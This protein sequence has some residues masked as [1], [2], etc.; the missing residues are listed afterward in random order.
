[1][2]P[3]AELTSSPHK[4]GA[5]CK[6]T[7]W[8]AQMAQRMADWPELLTLIQDLMAL[9]KLKEMMQL[10]WGSAIGNTD[11]VARFK[12]QIQKSVACSAANACNLGNNG[13]A[14]TGSQSPMS[15]PWMECNDAVSLVYIPASRRLE[16]DLELR[17]LNTLPKSLSLAHGIRE[18]I[19]S[20]ALCEQAPLAAEEASLRTGQILA[21]LLMGGADPDV[22]DAVKHVSL[23]LSVVVK[24]SSVMTP[25]LE[26]NSEWHHIDVDDAGEIQSIKECCPGSHSGII[27]SK[28]EAIIGTCNSYL[29]THHRIRALETQHI[30]RQGCSQ[31]P[32]AT[33]APPK[34]HAAW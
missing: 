19:S 14:H 32:D 12:S 3:S 5:V 4:D 26:G 25:L 29:D 11:A 30:N 10:R 28:L 33:I 20:A 6:F 27:I 7:N 9:L 17:S 2:H 22:C 16:V 34:H 23:K 15:V 21:C 31:S 24:A 18:V 8:L 1:M 13:Y